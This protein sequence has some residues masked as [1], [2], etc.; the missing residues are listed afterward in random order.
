MYIKVTV[1]VDRKYKI[2][3]M[4]Y[5]KRIKIWINISKKI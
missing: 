3:K 5:L 1:G 4:K 2:I